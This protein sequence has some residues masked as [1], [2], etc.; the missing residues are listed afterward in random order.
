MEHADAKDIGEF[1]NVGT[2]EDISIKNLAELVARIVGYSG[3]IVW[4]TSKPNGT[5]RK[6]LDVS[7]LAALGWKYKIGLEAGIASTYKDF[8]LRHN[9]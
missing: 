3:E 8:L 2:G 1:V 7:R 5:P 6:L 4:D 9:R